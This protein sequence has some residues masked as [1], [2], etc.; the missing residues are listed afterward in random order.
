MFYASK[1]KYNLTKQEN[2]VLTSVV[3]IGSSLKS[4]EG[5]KEVKYAMMQNPEILSK[6]HMVHL[7][8]NIL[9]MYK[10]KYATRKRLF[11]LIDKNI[12]SNM[13]DDDWEHYL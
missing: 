10:F 12:T 4:A 13:L 9:S 2:D 8:T 7:I 3:K 11:Q 6:P 1:K 5:E